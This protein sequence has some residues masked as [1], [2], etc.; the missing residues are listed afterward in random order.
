MR[1]GLLE[2]VSGPRARRA[3]G[4]GGRRASPR[5]RLGGGRL[6][7]P[8]DLVGGRPG[9]LDRLLGAGPGGSG[10]RRRLPL[11]ALK[12]P[13][14]EA[15]AFL[16]RRNLILR[17][18]QLFAQR[19]H[20]SGRLLN[21]RE[22]DQAGSGP[23]DESTQRPLESP[24]RCRGAALEGPG[25]GSQRPPSEDGCA[26]QGVFNP[27]LREPKLLSHY[28]NTRGVSALDCLDIPR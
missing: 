17:R 1:P 7:R 13:R 21:R 28:E 4:L 8:D 19:A 24:D 26:S 18:G 2:D 16:M 20:A 27:P 15:L 5:E 22:E 14:E 11:G 23:P 25:P 12:R 10:E 6:R 3:D 9:A